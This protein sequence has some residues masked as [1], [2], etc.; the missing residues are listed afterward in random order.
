[1][2]LRFGLASPDDAAHCT[3]LGRRNLVAFGCIAEVET[4]TELAWWPN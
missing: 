4:S 3:A 1:M 2:K